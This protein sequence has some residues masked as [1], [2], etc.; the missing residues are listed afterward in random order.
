MIRLLT[1]EDYDAVFELWKRTKGM[2]LRSL[3]D[4]YDGIKKFIQRNPETNFICEKN[5]KIVAVILCGHD[6]RRAYIYHAV[7]DNDFRKQGIGKLLVDKVVD[8]LKNIGIHKV[9]LVV[10]EDNI[11]GNGFWKSIGFNSR[12]DLIYRD[13]SIDKQNV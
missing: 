5:N 13:L 2:G 10:F 1:I 8:S 7:V 12:N 3:D 6:G 11:V 9:A 4:S